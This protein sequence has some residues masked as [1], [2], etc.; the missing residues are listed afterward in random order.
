MIKYPTTKDIYNELCRKY[1]SGDFRIIGNDRQQS[2][3]IEIQNANFIVDKPWIIR[4]PNYEYFNRELDWYKSQSLNV[5]DI[6]GG[7]PKMWRACADNNGYINSNYGWCIWSGE[8][9]YQYQHC[10]KKL[11]EDHHTREAC[12][13]YTRP[14]MQEDYKLNGM[15]DFICT[16]SVQVFINENKDGEKRLDY[17]VYMRSNDAVYGFDNDALWHMEVQNQLAQ[18]LSNRLNDRINP[19]DLYWNAGSLHVYERHFNLLNLEYYENC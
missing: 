5:N 15:H 7:A 16:Y 14:G 17:I 6:P 18:D 8:N 13:L 11:I 19:G 2:K 4:E 12:M 1:I 9:G 10:L 3:T